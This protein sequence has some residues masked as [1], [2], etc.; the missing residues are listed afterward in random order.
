MF[1]MLFFVGQIVFATVLCGLIHEGSHYFAA[2]MFGK[3]IK[4][5]FEWG[6][7]GGIKLVPRWTWKHPECLYDELVVICLAGFTVEVVFALID[8]LL[9][10]WYYIITITLLHLF[11]YNIYAGEANDFNVL[12]DTQHM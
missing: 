11:A 7:I 9:I 1:D 6:K 4:F 12:K 2:K 5:T 8:V 3:T 10:H